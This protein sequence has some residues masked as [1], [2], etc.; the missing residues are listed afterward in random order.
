MR[1]IFRF[2]TYLLA[3]AVLGSDPVGGCP[4]ISGFSPAQ[5]QSETN[6]SSL[7]RFSAEGI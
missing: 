3:A 1:R 7:N 4:G 2:Q 6:T 5:G